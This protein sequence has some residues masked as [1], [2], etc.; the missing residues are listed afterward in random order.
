MKALIHE[1]GKFIARASL[2]LVM[3]C[4]FTFTTR[5]QSATATLS[6]TVA[7]ANGAV[8]KNRVVKVLLRVLAAVGGGYAFSAA[9]VA[10]GAVAISLATPLPRGEAAMLMA[11]LGFVIYLAVLL[12]AFAERRLWL[13]WAVLFGGAACL[14]G[15]TRGLTPMLAPASVAGG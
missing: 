14:Y 8:I 3:S 9:M 6:G 13:V 11:M 1:S 7:D 2:L 4:V 15:L 5:A 10:F 12:W